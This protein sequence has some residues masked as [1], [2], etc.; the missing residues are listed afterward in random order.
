MAS[1]VRND[2]RL[3][4]HLR[5]NLK[6]LVEQAADELGQSVSD[7]AVAAI[8]QAAREVI[9][10]RNVTDLSNR[11]RDRLLA[12]LDDTDAKPNKALRRAA[13]KYKQRVKA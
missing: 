6:Q 2:T 5:S 8:V 3:N 11:D 9:Q 4:L 13:Q 7:F 10:R 1:T 12:L